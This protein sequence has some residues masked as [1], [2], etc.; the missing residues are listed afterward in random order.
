M[1]SKERMQYD[2]AS[3]CK[4]TT[5]LLMIKSLDVE[6]AETIR[7]REQRELMY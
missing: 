4:P 5:F 6:R 2:A 7:W 1:Y 3:S